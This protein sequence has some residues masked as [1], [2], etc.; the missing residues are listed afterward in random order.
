MDI[1]IQVAGAFALAA[2]LLT[3]IGMFSVRGR[4][5]LVWFRDQFAGWF[6]SFWL[7]IIAWSIVAG[8][9]AILLYMDGKFSRGLAEGAEIDP[10]AFQA[11]G[12]VFRFFA[13]IFLMASARAKILKIGTGKV[14]RRMGIAC[15]V[16]V[17]AHAVGIG[18]QAMDERKTQALATLEQH[19]VSETSNTELIAALVQ[20]KDD[21]E[22]RLKERVD[23]I[24]QK[25]LIIQTDGDGTN[26]GQDVPLEARKQDL[27][28]KADAAIDGIDAQIL[29]LMASGTEAKTE[30]I[31]AEASAK[32][33][34]SLFVGMAQLFTWDKEPSL[35]AMYICGVVF[36]VF[37]VGFAESIV[38]FLPKEIYAMHLQDAANAPK[39]DE[40]DASIP[41]GMVDLRMSQQEWEEYEAAKAVHD[42]IKDGAQKGARTRRRGKKIREDASYSRERV[43]NAIAKRKAGQSMEEIAQD[44]GLTV[45]GWR[46]T[47]EKYI[48]ND[49]EWELLLGDTEEEIDDEPV[50]EDD[51]AQMAN[52]LDHSSDDEGADENADEQP[53]A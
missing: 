31:A 16:I 50:D 17:F 34:A 21:I 42:N 18:L 9:F 20:Q 40:Y 48:E 47:Y 41:E 49:D 52:G 35:W 13:L 10:L 23:P 38:I 8:A 33:Y 14:W 36:I 19:E 46:V 44:R 15:S 39:R 53:S 37:W 26:D 11:M 3:L 51:P 32:P 22:R 5:A 12:W 24:E 27:Q 6:A 28:D 7:Y 30:A 4:E 2:F 25:I 1:I 43:E 29:A 45:N